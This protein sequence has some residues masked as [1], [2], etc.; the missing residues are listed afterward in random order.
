MGMQRHSPRSGGRPGACAAVLLGGTIL[1]AALSAGQKSVNDGVYSEAQASRGQEVFQNACTNCHDTSRFRG[2]AFLENL[3]GEPL[4][5]LYDAIRTTM[6]EDNPG[7][8]KPQQYA[9]IVSYLLR[10]NGF[11]AGSEELPPTDAA[12]KAVR[13]E[14]PP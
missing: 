14:A 5:G 8:L 12:M 6:P 11:P 1:A 3:T 9:D 2:P 7:G 13:I 4:A 10:L